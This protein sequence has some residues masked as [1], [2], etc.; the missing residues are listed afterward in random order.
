MLVAFGVRFLLYKV[1][2]FRGGRGVSR[3]RLWARPPCSSQVPE[4]RVPLRMVTKAPVPAGTWPR[5]P[6]AAEAARERSGDLSP[7]GVGP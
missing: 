6:A 1:P 4:A 3:R 5:C 7:F 2:R